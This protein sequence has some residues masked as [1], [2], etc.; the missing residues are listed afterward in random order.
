MKLACKNKR[1]SIFF[2]ISL[3][4]MSNTKYYSNK[5]VESNKM[6]LSYLYLQFRRLVYPAK[7]DERKVDYVLMV[8]GVQHK[9]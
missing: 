4:G 3:E 7:I 2:S 6:V 1:S 8:K 9:K 5:Q